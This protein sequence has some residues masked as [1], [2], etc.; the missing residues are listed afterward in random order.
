MV[1]GI[2]GLAAFNEGNGPSTSFASVERG[3]VAFA[4]ECA[5]CH[6]RLAEGTERGPNL[7]H[8]DYGP[9]VRSD[10]QLRRAVRE[11]MPARLGYGAMP[12]SPDVSERR[13]A[14]S[15]DLMRSVRLDP[16]APVTEGLYA[17]YLNAGKQ[18]VHDVHTPGAC[19]ILILG[20]TAEPSA[21]L[22]S[23]RIATLDIS[24]F[25]S[26]VLAMWPCASSVNA[27][28]YRPDSSLKSSG[29]TA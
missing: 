13:L 9:G 28:M 21:D 11:G 19:D 3:L 1:F 25:G 29:S 8:P 2:P 16:D 5:S 7:I 12:P 15:G 10:A 20:E 17:G 22:P 4:E 27:R 14:P 6:G 24:W 23:P 18:I 26:E